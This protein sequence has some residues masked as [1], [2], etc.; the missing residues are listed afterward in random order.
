MNLRYSAIITSVAGYLVFMAFGI[1]D[2][3]LYP[4]SSFVP[5]AGKEYDVQAVVESRRTLTSSEMYNLSLID[6]DGQKHI[7]KLTLFCSPSIILVPG[8]I[9]HLK[10]SLKKE[11]T[12]RFHDLSLIVSSYDKEKIE[13]AGTSKNPKFI[14]I[15]RCERL[16]NILGSMAL[17]KNAKYFIRALLFA[18]RSG[19]SKDRIM[20]MRNGGTIH[21][22]AVS[23]M[24]VGIIAALLLLLTIPLTLISHRA[25]RKTVVI[26]GIW[27]FVLLTGASFSAIRAA[28]MLTIT[29]A[30]YIFERRKDAFS[31][32]CYASLF[33][34]AIWPRAISD[35]GL[36]LSFVSVAALSLLAVPLN[37]IDHKNHPTVYK[38]YTAVLTTIIATA[39][40]WIL[41]G[42]YFG[43][44]PLRFIPSNVLLLP[45][46]PVYMTIGILHL[47]LAGIGIEI[48]W[49]SFLLD[50]TPDY[51]FDIL[52]SVSSPALIINI[53][54][55]PVILWMTGLASICIS[56]HSDRSRVEMQ[57]S[58]GIISSARSRLILFI[59]LALIVTSIILIVLHN[60]PL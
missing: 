25:L 2:V 55:L 35:I 46:L 44:V 11:E 32:L 39:A 8:D 26:L 43:S 31:A 10:D 21:A 14:F 3:N 29:I 42:Y 5:E 41:C 58:F 23:G 47:L 49:I 24:H 7:G 16:D 30:A 33:I 18:E 52:D 38:L 51:L 12:D 57:D 60:K 36:Q 34:L 53:T 22:L 28:I 40:T 54:L 6:I 50:K 56:I 13:I 17:G 45:L 9:I 1:M 4:V 19:V 20:T 27:A 15:K 59:G 48:N 37:P